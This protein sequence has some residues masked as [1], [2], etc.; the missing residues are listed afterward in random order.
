MRDARHTFANDPAALARL[1]AIIAKM[2]LAC[3][4]DD[5]LGLDKADIEFHREICRSSGN[6]IVINL[7]EAL[8]RQ[9]FIVLAWEN[10]VAP[11]LEEKVDNH[12]ALRRAIASGDAGLD[13]MLDRHI[14]EREIVRRCEEQSPEEASTA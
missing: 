13:D 1:D 7:W 4:D 5:R 6:E 12:R 3:R 11:N 9:A 2:E 8:A 10:L 14:I